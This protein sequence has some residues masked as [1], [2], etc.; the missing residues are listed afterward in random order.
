VW[1]VQLEGRIKVHESRHEDIIGRLERI[2]GKLDR[3]NGH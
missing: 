2:E 3:A 1:L